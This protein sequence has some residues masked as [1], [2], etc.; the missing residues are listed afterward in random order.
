MKAFSRVS[1]EIIDR[2]YGLMI[3][4]AGCKKVSTRAVDLRI[5]EI[6][7]YQAT[8][9]HRHERSESV[10]YVLEGTV[11]A[12]VD[13]VTR[14]LAKEEGIVIEPGEVHRIENRVATKAIVIEAMAPPFSKRDIDYIDRA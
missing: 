14:E 7:A 5:L 1:G 12:V 2:P 6:D 9:T 4:L 11:A 3:M 10:F 13:G 8:T